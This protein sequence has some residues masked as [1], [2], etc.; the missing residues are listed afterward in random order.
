MQDLVR[1]LQSNDAND[2]RAKIYN[3]NQTMMLLILANLGAFDEDFP[4][5][6]HN[7]AQQVQRLWRTSAIVPMAAN[8]AVIRYDCADGDN[9]ILFLYNE[10]PLQLLGCETTGLCKQSLILQRFSRFHDAD[11][12]NIFC[13]DTF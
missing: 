3:Q 8:L 1:F 11:C 7:I 13:S 6:R 12:M 9:D 10:K 4:L 2:H 5:T